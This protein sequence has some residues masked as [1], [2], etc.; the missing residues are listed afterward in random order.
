M[1]RGMLILDFDGT[2]TDAEEEGRPFREGYLKD[3]TALVA[4]HDPGPKEKAEEAA[5]ASKGPGDVFYQ[6]SDRSEF[7]D[8]QDLKDA[9]LEL[10]QELFL[11]EEELLFPANTQVAVFLSMDVGEY[12][13]LDS[14]EALD[15]EEIE[16]GLAH[17]SSPS[18]RSAR[19]SALRV[20][21]SLLPIRLPATAYG[22][23][24][25]RVS[26]MTSRSSS[27]S[28]ASA[29]S[30]RSSSSRAPAMRLGVKIPAKPCVS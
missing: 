23:P 20:A 3:L 21:S 6:E 11:L 17:S 15:D 9:V 4:F 16:I 18:R 8:V 30:S 25:M 5:E 24:A 10:N 26:A 14:V 29:V 2:L 19:P 13:A 1:M 28:S 22:R 7:G 12:F 27:A